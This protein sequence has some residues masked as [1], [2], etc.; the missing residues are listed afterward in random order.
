MKKEVQGTEFLSLFRN[1][2]GGWVEGIYERLQR[3]S[4]VAQMVKNLPAMQ[5]T[6]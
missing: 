4:Q 2:S 3:A 5:E 6:P 1:L